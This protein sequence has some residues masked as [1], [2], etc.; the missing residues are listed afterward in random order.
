MKIKEAK[1]IAQDL[2]APTVDNII[3]DIQ[4]KDLREGYGE[5]VEG[6]T[7]VEIQQVAKALNRLRGWWH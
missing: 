1:R 5:F 2:I 7:E 6:L 4:D 3:A